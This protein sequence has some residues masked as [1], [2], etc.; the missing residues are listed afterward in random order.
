LK[1]QDCGQGA[2]L[3]NWAQGTFSSSFLNFVGSPSPD[4]HIV[5]KRGL[6]DPHF[7]FKGQGVHAIA[8]VAAALA[9]VTP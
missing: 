8:L 2:K 1:A 5:K 3:E 9:I 7:L 6:L 4:L